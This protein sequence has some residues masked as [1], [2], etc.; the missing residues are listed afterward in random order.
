MT[1]ASTV[2]KYTSG[3][4]HMY[5]SKTEN[6]TEFQIHEAFGLTDDYDWFMDIRVS[7]F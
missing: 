5:A 3:L 1:G 7:H 6:P 4:L 2:C